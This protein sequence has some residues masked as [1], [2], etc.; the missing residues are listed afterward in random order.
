MCFSCSNSQ[1][2]SGNPLKTLLTNFEY[3]DSFKVEC[4]L[5]SELESFSLYFFQYIFDVV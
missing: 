2:S 5:F 1:E 4:I 3:L